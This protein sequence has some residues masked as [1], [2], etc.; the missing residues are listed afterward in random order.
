MQNDLKFYNA[1]NVIGDIGPAKFKKLID[2]FPNMGAAWQAS[3]YDLKQAG[4]LEKD[5]SHFLSRRREINPDA[6]LEKCQK[7][8]I[9]IITIKDSEYPKP[10][11]EIYDPPALLY[12]KG[13]LCN[14][15]LPKIA[16]VG[17]RK[18]T[19][20]G[21]QVTS[22]LAYNL[23][24]SGVI[25]VSGLALG[26]DGEA[27]HAACQAR[28]PSLAVLGSGVNE[29]NIYPRNNFLLSKKII[30]CRGALISEYPY[31]TPGFKSNFPQRNRLISGLSRAVLVTEC[32]QSSGA[33]ITAKFALDQNRDVFACPGSIFWENCEGTNELI[34][35]GAKLVSSAAD[36]LEELNL[37]SLVS[38]KKAKIT[39]KNQDEAKVLENLSSEPLHIDLLAKKTQIPAAKLLALL[40]QMELSSKVRNIGSMNYVKN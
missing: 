26:V 22:M 25:I 32:P 24:L 16:I 20:Y 28:A 6:E 19:S 39:P 4:F 10:L 37:E 18:M 35:M 40:T 13:T 1:I 11:S 14:D 12:I 38:I 9:K 33:L 8:N 7:E 17:T 23:A 21:K 27:H 2:F 3:A 34:K 5:I 29:A 15:D 30:E 31:G 36:I